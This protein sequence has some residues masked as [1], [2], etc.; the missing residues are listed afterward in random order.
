MTI[1]RLDDADFPTSKQPSQMLQIDVE[2]A[3]VDAAIDL[4]GK[5]PFNT[6][7]EHDGMLYL[8]EPGSFDANDDPLA[9]VE[10]F[11]TKTRQSQILVSERVIGGSVAEVAVSA[12]CAAAIVAGPEHD[13][14]PTSLV[15]FDP[16]TGQITAVAMAP[17]PG[18]DLQGLA[19]QGQTLY[20]GDRRE[21]AGGF[22]VHVLER[23]GDSCVLHES[24]RTI[25]LPQ[26]PVALRPAQ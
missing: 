15:T 21:G 9:G 26:R 20:V 12:G 17:T 14:N 7:A 18:Y 22:R 13:V 16:Q 25:D 3:S 1:E 10:R 19:W 2:T 4:Q 24:A 5:D 8:A 6:I 11:D 23:D